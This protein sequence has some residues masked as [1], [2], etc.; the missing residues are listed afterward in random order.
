MKSC[1]LPN[2]WIRHKRKGCLLALAIALRLP[3][4]AGDEPLRVLSVS[5]APRDSRSGADVFLNHLEAGYRISLEHFDLSDPETDLAALEEGAVVFLHVQGPVPE[6]RLE[7]L[8]S[9]VM[10]GRPL[11]ALRAAVQ[12]SGE[13]AG[14]GR[15]AY[16][17]R[18]SGSAES[19]MTVRTRPTREGVDH[20]VFDGVE[21]IRSR[22]RLYQFASLAEDAEVLMIGSVPDTAAQPVAW[23]REQGG[24]RI[25][26]SSLGGEL[27]FENGSVQRMIANALFWAAGRTPQRHRP[28]DIVA[29]PWREEALTLPLRSR[30]VAENDGPERVAVA[31]ETLPISAAALMVTNLFDT[32]WCPAVA[33]QMETLA[34]RVNTLVS[35]AREAGILIVHIPSETFGYYAEHPARRRVE[36][37]MSMTVEGN[38]PIHAEWRR[39][40][41]VPPMPLSNADCPCGGRPYPAWTRQHPAIEIRDEDIISSDGRQIYGYLLTRGVDTLFYVG[42]HA[43]TTLVYRSYGMQQMYEWGMECVLVRDLTDILFNPAADPPMSHEAALQKVIEHLE[44]HLVSTI[45]HREFMEAIKQ[46]ENRKGHV[47]R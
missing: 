36:Q 6:G 34:E 47:L 11:V 30:T 29:G 10:S 5:D 19:T 8:R 38:Y 35:T 15:D 27:D 13:G 20:P 39:R 21:P 45:A 2:A 26:Y 3:F 12:A 25:F 14:R 22:H 37:I 44:M 31:Y 16:G 1:S 33:T 40:A 42:T 9:V 28:P 43:N 24:R 7:P 4:A 41:A 17:V 18:F 46:H 23:A 32:H